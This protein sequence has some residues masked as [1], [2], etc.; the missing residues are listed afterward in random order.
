MDQENAILQKLEALKEELGIR[1][2]AIDRRLAALE[3]TPE[4]AA[5]TPANGRTEPD[6][7][8]PLHTV[9]VTV[10][11]LHDVSKVRVVED[12]FAA[13]DG[14]ESVSLHTL[15]GDAAHLE[16]EARDDVP[17]IAGLR[18]TLQLAFD[19][20][21]SDDSSFTIALAQPRAE[22]EGGVAAPGT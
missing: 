12:A 18:R 2:D 21:E 20:V 8:M 10:T 16:V 22:R 13:I 15:R 5:A 17:L 19:L 14:V 3:G 1:L 4:G 6:P 7:G 11:P 9:S